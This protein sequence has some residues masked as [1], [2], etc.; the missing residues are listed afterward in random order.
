MTKL[1]NSERQFLAELYYGDDDYLELDW[2][3]L[4]NGDKTYCG[5]LGSLCKKNVLI[6]EEDYCFVVN[7]EY[8]H[9]IDKSGK[10]RIA[11]VL[12][13]NS[14]RIGISDVTYAEACNA[15]ERLSNASHKF[16]VVDLIGTPVE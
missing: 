7:D 6:E 4:K 12:A 5:I 15:I 11:Q 8:E 2:K 3:K 14:L 1:T 9:M 16:I 10:Y 13:D